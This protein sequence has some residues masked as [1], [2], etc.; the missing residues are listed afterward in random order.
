MRLLL[1]LVAAIVG[2]A[3]PEE[4]EATGDVLACQPPSDPSLALVGAAGASK[5]LLI[6]RYEVTQGE[7]AAFLA[8][9]T[10]P[11]MPGCD[12]NDD[13]APSSSCLARAEVAHGDDL[14]AVCLDVCDAAAYCRASGR[15]LCEAEGGDAG[16]LGRHEW[17]RACTNDEK[18]TQYPYP[19]DG[20]VGRCNV[21]GAQATEPGEHPTCVNQSGVADLSGNVAEWTLPCEGSGPRASCYARGGSF[22]DPTIASARCTSHLALDAETRAPYLGFRCCSMQLPGAPP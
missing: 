9:D 5:C 18:T 11:T 4:P 13:L 1:L 8:S 15:R 10:R 14:P 3:P 19:G 22:I 17:I 7:Y 20:V 16:P 6:D 21:P 12:W 2:C